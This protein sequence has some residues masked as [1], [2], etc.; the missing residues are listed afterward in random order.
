MITT[1]AAFFLSNSLKGI[2]EIEK[3]NGIRPFQGHHDIQHNDTKHNDTKHNDTQHKGG[4]MV[5]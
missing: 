3:L 5:C 2:D 1:L 4:V